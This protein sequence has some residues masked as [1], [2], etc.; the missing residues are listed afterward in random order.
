M[1]IKFINIP[2]IS[3]PNVEKATIESILERAQKLYPK[4][5]K[6]GSEPI[7]VIGNGVGLR[8][9]RVDGPRIESETYSKLYVTK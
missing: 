7:K 5:T 9:S 8:P 6:Y 4:L 3:N 2:Y 1:T